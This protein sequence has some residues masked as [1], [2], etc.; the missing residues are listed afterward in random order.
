MTA[1]VLPPPRIATRLETER[2]IIRA[3][4]VADAA[5]LNAL[6]RA[7]LP[8]LRPWMIWANEVPPLAATRARLRRAVDEYRRGLDLTMLLISRRSG[9]IVGASGLHRIDW[10]VPRFEIGYWCGSKYTGRGYITEACAALTHFAFETLGAARVDIRMDA[11]NA[12]SRAVAE[13]LGYKLEGILRHDRRD[14]FGVLCD[15]CVYACVAPRD[16][17]ADDL[18]GQLSRTQAT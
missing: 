1:V 9:R 14:H 8:E 11:R 13:R 5:E 4:L 6:V 15:A 12:A 10:S 3:P 16:P 18:V 2:L 17:R 7:S